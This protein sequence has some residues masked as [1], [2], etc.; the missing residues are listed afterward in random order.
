MLRTE[1]VEDDAETLRAALIG[2]QSSEIWTALPGILDSFDATKMTA[3][4]Q[5]AIK[6]IFRLKDGSSQVVQMPQCLDVPVFFPGGG[7][8]TLTFP[9]KAGDEGLLVFSSR[10][11]DAWWQNGGVQPQAEVRFHDLS[12]GF[13]FPGFRSVPRVLN[14]NVATDAVELRSDDRA[15]FV[16][17]KAGN[18]LN[19]QADANTSVQMAPKVIN[20]KAGNATINMSDTEIDITA[21]TIKIGGKVW[22]THSHSGVTTGGGNTGGVV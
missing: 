19:V 6:G 9:V 13:F 2:W 8:F 20:L 17:M 21:A 5:P 15:T 1:R 3:V 16:Q 10:C 22:A 14:P 7:G 12:D 11:I 4:V 18:I